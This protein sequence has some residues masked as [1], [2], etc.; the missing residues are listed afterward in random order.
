MCRFCKLVSTTQRQSV[1]SRLCHHKP[2]TIN[3]GSDPLSRPA[4]GHACGDRGRIS[5][6]YGWTS[7][8]VDGL[9]RP[10]RRTPGAAA[11][12]RC[13]LHR[14]QGCRTGNVLQHEIT[15]DRPPQPCLERRLAL[16]TATLARPADIHPSTALRAC[17]ECSEGTRLAPRLAACPEVPPESIE[18]RSRRVGLRRIP[19][20]SAMKSAQAC[21]RLGQILVVDPLQGNAD[22]STKLRTGLEGAAQSLP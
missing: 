9:V 12:L 4:R 5:G 2:L 1:A 19:N 14:Q 16:E 18:G 11:P 10:C 15:L 20:D 21:N 22:P 8:C 7:T 6:A 3:Y 13:D 17:P